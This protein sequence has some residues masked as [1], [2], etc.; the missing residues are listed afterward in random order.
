MTIHMLRMRECYARQSLFRRNL[1]RVWEHASYSVDLEERQSIGTEDIRRSIV[2]PIG[3]FRDVQ[4]TAAPLPVELIVALS[5][6]SPI[7]ELL[8]VQVP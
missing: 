5:L 3:Q 7:Q 2:H 4:D 8:L 6:E 1:L